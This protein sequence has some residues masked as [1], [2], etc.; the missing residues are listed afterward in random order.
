MDGSADNTMKNFDDFKEDLGMRESTGDYH[1]VNAWGFMG[2]YQ[3]GK[4][5]LWDLGI[6]I[7]SYMPADQTP[8]QCG[9]IILTVEEFLLDRTLQDKI[10][11]LHVIKHLKY[12]RK[13]YTQYIPIYTES[14][15]V[16]GVHLKGFGGLRE[17]LKGEDNEDGLGTKIS[18][19]VEMFS[20]YDLSD[21]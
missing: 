8:A 10:F 6:S 3:F 11:K 17:F 5:R 14:G 16:A 21:L 1:C 15:L 9:K 4:P 18:E 20:G 19:Y 12:L 2:K 7:D 13:K